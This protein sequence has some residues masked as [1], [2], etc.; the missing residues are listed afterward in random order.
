M[1]F[2]DY[3][4]APGTLDALLEQAIAHITLTGSAVLTG[5]ILG[6]ISGILAHRV[7]P[8]RAALL[9]LFSVLLTI[10]SLAFFA[11]LIPIVGIGAGP[12]Y[13]A[14]TCYTL[15]FI[16][17]NT[18]AGLRSVDPAVVES[19]RGMGMSNMQRLLRMELPVALPIILTGVRVATLLV[20]GVAATAALVGGP[21]LGEEIYLRGIRRIGSP[22]ALEALLGGTLGVLIV[23][24]LFDLFY[25]LVGRLTISKGL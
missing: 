9:T 3:L 15:L 16:T 4:T 7:L 11:L 1:G 20:V 14:L 24:T 6:V 12:A 8:L 17:R 10:P 22:G 18:L 21:G 25:Q 2:I 13:I 5:A 19:A 23:A